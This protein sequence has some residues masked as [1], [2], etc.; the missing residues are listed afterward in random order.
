[1]QTLPNVR[2]LA[3]ASILAETGT[4]LAPFPTADQMASWAGLC[5]GNR[6]SAGIQKRRP[7]DTR[8]LLSAY[9]LVQCAW[10]ATRKQGSVFP[11]SLSAI[12]VAARAETG[13]RNNSAPDI[14]HRVLHV[15]AGSAL[16]RCREHP[17]TAATEAP[18]TSS[19]LLLA[20]SRA[21]SSGCG[22]LKLSM[23]GWSE[24]VARPFSGEPVPCPDAGL[25]DAFE[26]HDSLEYLIRRTQDIL[27]RFGV[28]RDH[29]QQH[30]S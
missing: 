23:A 7:D 8:E 11:G 25:A 18:G 22:R 20:S 29:S 15:E 9:P 3:A 1:M 27:Y 14:D 28:F 4:D 19:P 17:S 10:A 12:I 24:Q 6:E 5:P 13:H 2:Q 21:V 30:A 26:G 16:S